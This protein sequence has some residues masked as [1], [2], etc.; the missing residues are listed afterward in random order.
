MS[1]PLPVLP[2]AGSLNWRRSGGRRKYAR[3]PM[4]LEALTAYRW[5]GFG[6]EFS[7]VINDERCKNSRLSNIRL[8]THRPLILTFYPIDSPREHALL[9]ADIAQLVKAAHS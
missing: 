8:L 9:R 7:C 3:G 1:T 2:T 5:I 4:G 6:D